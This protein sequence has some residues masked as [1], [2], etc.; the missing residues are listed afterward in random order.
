MSLLT[1]EVQS[2]LAASGGEEV[3]SLAA[4]DTVAGSNIIARTAIGSIALD[5]TN[6][7]KQF[8]QTDPRQIKQVSA[9]TAG[10]AT[11]IKASVIARIAILVK[12]SVIARIATSIEAVFS[13]SARI[14]TGGATT[15]PFERIQSAER[16]PWYGTAVCFTA[17]I[18]VGDAVARTTVVIEAVSRSITRI[19]QRRGCKQ[20][21]QTSTQPEAGQVANCVAWIT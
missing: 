20:V 3:S 21:P 9:R 14:A 1:I 11:A 12:A 10:V 4:A 2:A 8:R 16:K 17:G 15:K 19:A 7:P 18:A 13:T 6:A 5:D